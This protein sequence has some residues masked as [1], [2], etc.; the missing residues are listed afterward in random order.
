MEAIAQKLLAE[1]QVQLQHPLAPAVGGSLVALLFAVA[2]FYLCAGGS[3]T[4]TKGKK[5]RS[6]GVRRS[7]RWAELSMPVAHQS[8]IA[9]PHSPPTPAAGK[10]SLLPSSRRPWRALRP[11]RRPGLW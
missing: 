4:T 5:A 11:P 6:E 9:G 10:L 7:T 1:L 8:R 3:S 2:V